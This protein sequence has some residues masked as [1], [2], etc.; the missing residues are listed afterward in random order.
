MIYQGSMS[1]GNFD[2]Q[3]ENTGTSSASST[4]RVPP[5]LWISSPAGTDMPSAAVQAMDLRGTVHNPIASKWLQASHI[6][7]TSKEHAMFM[8]YA[9]TP[10]SYLYL[11][12]NMD[13][14]C[15]PHVLQHLKSTV[16]GSNYEELAKDGLTA[17]EGYA[18]TVG[19]LQGLA[20]GKNFLRGGQ[21]YSNG[22]DSLELIVW[23]HFLMEW[24]A[25][26][27]LHAVRG[28]ENLGD[29]WHWKHMPKGGAYT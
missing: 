16:Q 21:D 2:I 12:Q 26:R 8:R 28:D 13:E 1:Y 3:R 19:M 11:F 27:R 24:R 6:D 18:M 22:L 9:T 17:G 7:K 4:Y 15:P 10:M 23:G 29:G 5:M 25:D 14:S 20:C